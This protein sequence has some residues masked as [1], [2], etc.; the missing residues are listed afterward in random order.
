MNIFTD[1]LLLCTATVYGVEKIKPLRLDTTDKIIRL[2]QS[3][4]VLL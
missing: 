1:V 4:D 3:I 2:K